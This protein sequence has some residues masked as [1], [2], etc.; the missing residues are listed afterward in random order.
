MD[1]EPNRH[2]TTIVYILNLYNLLYN[3]HN[4]NVPMTNGTVS[5]RLPF[6]ISS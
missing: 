6:L 3:N 5:G 1:M 4:P 2:P